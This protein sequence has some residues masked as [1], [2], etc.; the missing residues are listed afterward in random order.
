MDS[1]TLVDLSFNM[2]DLEQTVQT[3]T[4]API[5]RRVWDRDNI[6]PPPPLM[7]HP[8]IIDDLRQPIE[9]ADT[10]T[11]GTKPRSVP[12][13]LITVLTRV[14]RTEIPALLEILA[15]EAASCTTMAAFRSLLARHKSRIADLVTRN[16]K[17]AVDLCKKQKL[18]AFV[19]QSSKLASFKRL[20]VWRDAVAEVQKLALRSDLWNEE[21]RNFLWR[22]LV[23]TNQFSW[24]GNNLVDTYENASLYTDRE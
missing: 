21:R 12:L 20:S 22:R 8:G 3:E 2:G 18:P 14:N 9:P 6:P 5:I 23:R 15:A 13:E 16:R 10:L 24:Y 1:E 19:I 17:M 11:F 7:P 4:Q